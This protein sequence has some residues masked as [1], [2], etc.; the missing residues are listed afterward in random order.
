MSERVRK[1]LMDIEVIRVSVGTLA[2]LRR[3]KRRKAM[4]AIHE[5]RRYV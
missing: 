2:R 5:Q 1:L 4:P 3:Q